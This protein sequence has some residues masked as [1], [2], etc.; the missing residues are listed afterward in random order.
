MRLLRVPSCSCLSL[1]GSRGHH[2]INVPLPRTLPK[3]GVPNHPLETRA[4]RRRTTA[5]I[6]HQAYQSIPRWLRVLESEGAAPTRVEEASLRDYAAEIEVAQQIRIGQGLD[7][8]AETVRLMIREQEDGECV[9]GV[10][11]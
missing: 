9:L 4:Q 6:L 3:L 2:T 1:L 11:G 8:A 7:P 10:E 5:M